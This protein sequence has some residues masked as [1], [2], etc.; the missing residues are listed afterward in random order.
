MPEVDAFIG[1]DQVADAG[2]II[3][4]VLARPAPEPIA[5]RPGSRTM[6][7]SR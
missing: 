3:E 6:R 1:L 7:G 4:Q 5:V 2:G